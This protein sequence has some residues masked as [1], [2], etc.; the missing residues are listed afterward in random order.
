M[1]LKPPPAAVSVLVASTSPPGSGSAGT[2]S[3]TSTTTLPRCSSRPNGPG[4]S[5]GTGPHREES[6]VQRVQVQAVD[7]GHRVPRRLRERRAPWQ[8]P[9][10]APVMAAMVSQSPPR[11]AATR[12]ASHGSSGTAAATANAA[13]NRFLG[14]QAGADQPVHGVDDLFAVQP[15]GQAGRPGDP[16]AHVRPGDPVP[17]PGSARRRGHRDPR[18]TGQ[19]NPVDPR[20]DRRGDGR[21]TGQRD[22]GVVRDPAGRRPPGPP[23]KR[24]S[25]EG[26]A[27]PTGRHPHGGAVGDS[28]TAPPRPTLGPGGQRV[29]RPPARRAEQIERPA[30][31]HRLLPG[32]QAAGKLAG[33]GLARRPRQRAGQAAPPARCH[34]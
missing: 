30:G 33:I 12:Q 29:Q 21:G 16:R 22:P 23:S 14:G 28:R 24:R 11:D 26:V 4:R 17:A 20:A 2:V 3:T 34:R 13:G 15:G 9:Q 31:A 25:S 8:A 10:M 1:T 6:P 19:R 7:P 27:T 18:G 5:P 32:Q